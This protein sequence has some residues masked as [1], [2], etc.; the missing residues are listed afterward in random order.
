MM[1][2]DDMYKEIEN[3]KYHKLEKQRI[4]EQ[5]IWELNEKFRLYY[6]TENNM[7]NHFRSSYNSGGYTK[8]NNS[9]TY[10]D[11]DYVFDYVD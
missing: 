6:M 10:V 9:T 3:E 7:N 5:K 1:N 8:K 4:Q 11:E 2:L